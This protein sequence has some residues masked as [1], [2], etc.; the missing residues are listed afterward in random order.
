MT[1]A[2]TP[3]SLAGIGSTGNSVAQELT[4]GV[5][6]AL[7]LNNGAVRVLAGAGGNG[8]YIDMNELRNKTNRITVNIN[9]GTT[10]NYT[11]NTSAVS[12]YSYGKTDA[13]FTV[14]SGNVVGSHSTGSA[15]FTVDTSWAA[16]DT[17]TV[18][19]QSG[20]YISGMGGSGGYGGSINYGNGNSR[21]GSNGTS[22]GVALL[23]QRYTSINNQGGIWGGGG[24]GGG[25]S[26][27]DP[28]SK[29]SGELWGS[30]GGGGAGQDAGAGYGWVQMNAEYWLTPAGNGS[31]G[32]GGAY[33]GFT[34]SGYGG[35]VQGYGNP[36]G[37]GGGP[38]AA[39][40]NGNVVPSYTS[41][42]GGSGGYCTSPGSNANIN[43]LATGTRYGTIA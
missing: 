8:T 11:A 4:Y 18:V 2:T 9:I 31:L 41:G 3:I 35:I 25:G 26:I 28:V 5:Y 29:S 37:Y 14:I 40:G 15:S 19:V 23:I 30:N 13:I 7:D 20:A 12:G 27:A 34:F 16:G 43:W 22:G 24:G 32:G 10:Y 39:G 36:G 42:V 33:G 38:G 6:N 21:N 17:V 1:T